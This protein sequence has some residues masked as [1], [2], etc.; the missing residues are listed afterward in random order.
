MDPQMHATFFGTCPAD[1]TLKKY[2]FNPE[3]GKMVGECPTPPINQAANNSKKNELMKL[4]VFVYNHG[5]T[6]GVIESAHQLREE[7]EKTSKAVSKEKTAFL[8][9]VLLFAVASA[10]SNNLM[11]IKAFKSKLIKSGISEQEIKIKVPL[12]DELKGTGSLEESC[13]VRYII[14]CNNTKEQWNFPF[15]YIIASLEKRAVVPDLSWVLER[16]LFQPPTSPAPLQATYILTACS[17]F[18]KLTSS[19]TE[20]FLLLNSAKR[21]VVSLNRM[22]SFLTERSIWEVLN[23]NAEEIYEFHTEKW[24]ETILDIKKMVKD[25]PHNH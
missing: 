6:K 22:T 16:T 7:L 2:G 25:N 15:I 3:S 24:K 10:S 19:L 5:H 21:K 14:T 1:D 11:A 23:E 13:E 18:D 12:L 8:R 9:P 20:N 4:P 17:A